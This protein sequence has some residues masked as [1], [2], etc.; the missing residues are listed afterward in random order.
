MVRLVLTH[1]RDTGTWQQPETF[2]CF[3]NEWGMTEG[4]D[5]SGFG[6]KPEPKKDPPLR[7]GWGAS[8]VL[9]SR[10]ARAELAGGEGAQ[11]R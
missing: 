6:K 8:R 5:R 1:C 3:S 9:A 11:G 10:E 2:P 7:F 4:K